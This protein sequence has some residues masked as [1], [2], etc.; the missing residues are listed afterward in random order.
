MQTWEKIFGDRFLDR[1]QTEDCPMLIAVRRPAFEMDT[2]FPV[3]DYHHEL[4]M[5]G[6]R[7]AKI[8]EVA[9]ETSVLTELKMF[10]EEFDQNEVE[11]VSKGENQQKS[12]K[13]DVFPFRR[14]AF[15]SD[16]VCVGT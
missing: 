11:L 15:Q 1:Y 7:L 10:K 16:M 5:K 3:P 12:G 6:P 8:D 4:L 9:T 14:L 2:R 13:S